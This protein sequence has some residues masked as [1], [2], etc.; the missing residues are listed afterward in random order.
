ALPLDPRALGAARDHAYRARRR[1]GPHRRPRA[2]RRR[3]RHEAVLAAR[4]RRP[5]AERAPT[6]GTA[7]RRPGAAFLRSARDRSRL[8]R[9][10]VRRRA[11]EADSEGVRLALLPRVASATRLLARPA[12]DAGL[13]IR[14]RTRH[15]HG[16]RPRAPAAREDRARPIAPA[17]PRDALGRRLQVHAVI[18]LAAAVTLAT[19]A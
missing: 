9:S 17:S 11:T 1:G 3:L 4:A 14:G 7:R 15:R 5:S 8:A 2:R 12:D 6:R 18:Q 19:L 10:R 13:G 16:H